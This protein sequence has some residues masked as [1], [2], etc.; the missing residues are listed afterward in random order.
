M[1]G[2]RILGPSDV[3][4]ANTDDSFIQPTQTK[5]ITLPQVTTKIYHGLL[6]GKWLSISCLIAPI[7]ENDL[8]H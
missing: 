1:A 7:D 3:S 4:S 8:A 2:K 5:F 6:V